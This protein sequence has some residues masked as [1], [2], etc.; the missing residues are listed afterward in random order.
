METRIVLLPPPGF[1]P[2]FGRVTRDRDRWEKLEREACRLRG[3]VYLADK[4]IGPHEIG[5]DGG[6]RLP[7]DRSSWQLLS[8]NGDEVV[9]A[10]L[11]ITES[12]LSMSKRKG[13]LPHVDESLARADLV[14]WRKLAAEKYLSNVH[15]RFGDSRPHFYVLGGWASDDTCSAAA[16]I[17]AL[18]PWALIRRSRCACALAICSERH[19]SH[20][21]LLRTG[22]VPV[23]PR[24]GKQ[25]YFDPNYGCRVGLVG[26]E[27][28]SESPF[29]ARAVDRLALKL[30]D[31]EIVCADSQ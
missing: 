3:K 22:A 5:A 29:L 26:G 14:P 19:G 9:T 28:F 7:I 4:A 10:T 13:R 23:Y 6:Y 8:M 15:L 16:A 18:A 17:L 11:R 24:N 25:M 2:A 27:V 31:S 30:Q 12:P 20:S 21:Q 1:V